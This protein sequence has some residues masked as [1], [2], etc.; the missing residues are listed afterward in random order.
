MQL[1]VLT[2]GPPPGAR[3]VHTGSRLLITWGSEKDAKR[4]R[5]E[6]SRANGFGT[7]IETHTVDGTSWAPNI[8][9]HKKQYRHKLYWR[10]AAVDIRGGVGSFAA[11]AFKR[12]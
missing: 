9:L 10:V 1:P 3:G 6:V 4:Y 2:L 7:R 5:V 8:D 12:H 11:G